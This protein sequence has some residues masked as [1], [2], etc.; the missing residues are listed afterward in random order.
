MGVL[1]VRDFEGFKET[2]HN[3]PVEEVTDQLQEKIGETKENILEAFKGEDCVAQKR[4]VAD[5]SLLAMAEEAAARE[6]RCNPLEEASWMQVARKKVRK[7][8]SEHPELKPQLLSTIF[9]DPDKDR[10]RRYATS[11]SA[12]VEPYGEYDNRSFV[13]GVALGEIAIN[14]SKYLPRP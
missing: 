6:P 4:V 14:R 7:L 8:A 3:I 2:L 12:A 13:V 9:F 11:I 5:L 10:R 1:L